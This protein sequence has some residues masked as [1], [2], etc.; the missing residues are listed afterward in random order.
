MVKYM[1][2]ASYTADGTK[3]LL[4]EGGSSRRATVQKMVSGLGGKLEAFYYA[5][6]DSDVY[7]IIDIPD[8]TT[9]A[10]L[11]LAINASGTVQLSTIPLLTPEEIDAASKKSVA[12]RAPG[13]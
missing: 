9:A 10:A 5:F 1:I 13:A 4:K 12:Y 11:S 6:G 3:G 7:A 2:K 8:A